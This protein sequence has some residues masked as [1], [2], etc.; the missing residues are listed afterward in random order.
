MAACPRA[1][2]W[3]RW[4][5]HDGYRQ[6]Q[7]DVPAIED[8]RLW[9]VESEFSNVLHQG[10]RDGNTLSAVLRDCWDGVDLTPPPPHHHQVEPALRQRPAR[11]PERRDLTG[12]TDQPDERL[13]TYQWL[14]QPLP[15][16]LGRAH[17]DA[18]IPEGN[19]A[20]HGRAVGAQDAGGIGLLP[21][22][23]ARR[24]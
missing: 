19:A 2:D 8:K 6:G 22:R 23:P 16:D 10:R 4:L 9:V 15:D 12:R 21:R 11:L 14:R 1:K 24:A 3:R 18:A 17:A 7:Q 5:I 13:R 20:G